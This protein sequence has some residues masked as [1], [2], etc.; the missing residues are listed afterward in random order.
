M[1]FFSRA[2]AFIEAVT[3]P[4]IEKASVFI[5]VAQP[6][7]LAQ[8]PQPGS[9]YARRIAIEKDI[10][11][12]RAQRAKVEK[13][14]EAQRE[15]ERRERERI[16]NE[17][18]P[19]PI[20]L[21]YKIYTRVS[22]NL[23]TKNEY[24]QL[25]DK[26]GDYIIDT[27][28]GYFTHYKD[29][30]NKGKVYKYAINN[31][32]IKRLDV[33][34]EFPKDIY[35]QMIRDTSFETI[36]IRENDPFFKMLPFRKTL[37]MYNSLLYPAR[38]YQPNEINM[39][40]GYMY[41]IGM[42][43]KFDNLRKTIR[44]IEGSAP[45]EQFFIDAIAH[46]GAVRDAIKVEAIRFKMRN[47]PQIIDFKYIEMNDEAIKMKINNTM[48]DGAIFQAGGKMYINPYVTENYKE[49]AC[50]P[51]LILN[52]LKSAHDEKLKK[53][54]MTV[55]YIQSA[56]GMT[57]IDDGV[58]IDTIINFFHGQNINIIILDIFGNPIKYMQSVKKPKISTYPSTVALLAHNNHIY[59]C[60]KYGMKELTQSLR[61]DRIPKCDNFELV[62][63]IKDEP[64]AIKENLLIDDIDK[65]IETI[66]EK[67]NVLIY[68]KCSLVD[69]IKNLRSKGIEVT[70]IIGS[71]ST[72]KMIKIGKNQIKNIQ[73]HD[74]RM[75]FNSID[76]VHKY[77]FLKKKL[78]GFF[79]NANR[80]TY[81]ADVMQLF[82]ACSDAN[83]I[84][85]PFESIGLDIK[86]DVQ[87]DYNK[88]YSFCLTKINRFPILLAHDQWKRVDAPITKIDQINDDYFYII[89]YKDV[90]TMIE[91]DKQD[92]M[93]FIFASKYR[94]VYYGSYLKVFMET[95][96]QLIQRFDIEFELKPSKVGYFD[97][98]T[99]VDE[100]YNSNIDTA[101]KKD[102]VNTFIGKCG[103]KANKKCDMRMIVSDQEASVLSERYSNLHSIGDNMYI[104]ISSSKTGLKTGFYTIQC[105][106]YNLA[107]FYL[108]H[109]YNGCKNSGMIVTGIHTDCVQ[110]SMTKPG[111]VD[112]FITMNPNVIGADVGQ[113]KLEKVKSAIK[114]YIDYGENMYG[115]STDEEGKKNIYDIVDRIYA[116]KYQ[117]QAI[118]LNDEFDEN[119]LRTHIMDSKYPIKILGHYPG[120][121]K[122]TTVMRALKDIGILHIVPYGAQKVKEYNSVTSHDFLKIYPGDDG[123]IKSKMEKAQF[124]VNRELINKYQCFLFDEIYLNDT[125]VLSFIQRTMDKYPTKKFIAA[126][127][128]MQLEPI[129]KNNVVV[130]GADIINQMFP[131]TIVL[132]QIKRADGAENQRKMKAVLD[133]IDG[134]FG[135]TKTD[136]LDFIDKTF[137]IEPIDCAQ[138][139]V[140][141]ATNYQRCVINRMKLADKQ[142][143]SNMLSVGDKCILRERLKYRIGCGIDGYEILANNEEFIIKALN[144][145]EN[146]QLVMFVMERESEPGKLYSF[147]DK[148]FSKFQPCWAQT[149]HQAQS[150]TKSC[151]ISIV[152]PD[153]L[154]WMETDSL[155]RWLR[156][157]VSRATSIDNINFIKSDILSNAYFY[158]MMANNRDM[159]GQGRETAMR[160]FTSTN[161][162]TQDEQKTDYRWLNV[163]FIN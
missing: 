90:A 131:M 126:G 94:T 34:F 63:K 58:D 158:K 9:E 127:D 88:Y 95:Y 147:P 38:A 78:Y 15:N 14:L 139:Y 110:I 26:K 60:N 134:L 137:K 41:K 104:S 56:L 76:D 153:N 132:R 46:R 155:V 123:E 80:S 45:E 51:M 72:A 118:T 151:K 157:A 77:N 18:K 68:T 59:F 54:K 36:N 16:E 163:P 96:P 129:E 92:T 29:G 138:D 57:N 79:N 106:V 53:T 21:E 119:E 25:P 22:G 145:A 124:D 74:M 82:E 122:T 19:I 37:I 162:W 116:K 150:K 47:V 40:D 2:K 62:E 49:D 113:W 23:I 130:S 70:Q 141:T 81:G 48:P 93:D 43:E 148:Q 89:K 99:L 75:K 135:K 20:T 5:G 128:A 144:R 125:N 44:D 109:M 6:I 4:I 33:D 67:Q 32:A 65:I 156:V 107:R 17:S 84:G 117:D 30:S 71:T 108:A 86:P 3:K 140:I 149:C 35:L 13:M 146:G 31:D 83:C 154:K 112:D 66:A 87:F 101:C 85:I 136:V 69:I 28:L 8:A 24:N 159:E 64:L 7:P 121:G 97:F 120:V 50:V 142:R 133:S 111:Q 1:S 12:E 102:L 91:K 61:Q 42:H 115:S 143:Q 114:K 55:E 39:Y 52:I 73:T 105:M 160:K 161:Y 152:Y 98:K 103:A 11:E 27:G 100:I 10:E